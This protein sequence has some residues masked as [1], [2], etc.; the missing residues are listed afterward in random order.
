MEGEDSSSCDSLTDLQGENLY[1]SSAV[2]MGFLGWGSVT[3]ESV[4]MIKGEDVIDIP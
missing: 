3:I 4:R 2:A 1:N